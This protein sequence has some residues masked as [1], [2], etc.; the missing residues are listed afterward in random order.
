MLENLKQEIN[1][2]VYV[3]KILPN[4]ASSK[5][6]LKEGDLIISIDG[7]K[8]NTINSLREYIY[9]KKAGDIVVLELLREE[10]NLQISISLEKK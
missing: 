3:S 2:G 10:K 4:S 8:L 5:S 6:A 9:T 1:T 7:N